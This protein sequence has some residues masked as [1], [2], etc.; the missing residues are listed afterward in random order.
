MAIKKTKSKKVNIFAPTLNRVFG[1][2]IVVLLIV[3]IV[4]GY[5]L[6]VVWQ[7]LFG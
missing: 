3:S 4:Q 5:L 1:L 6:S 2:A 7:E